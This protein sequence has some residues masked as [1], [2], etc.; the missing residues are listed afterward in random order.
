MRGLAYNPRST[1]RGEP[2]EQLE[3]QSYAL[4]RVRS[5]SS[6]AIPKWLRAGWTDLTRAPQASLFYGVVLT[7][8]GYLLTRFIGQGAYALALITGFLLMGPFLSM[9]LYDISRTLER[10]ES[11]RLTATLLAWRANLPAIGLYA[12]ILALLMAVWMRVSVVVVA[13]FFEGGVPSAAT[14]WSDIVRADQGLVFLLV[15]AAAGFGF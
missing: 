3:Q 15:Y 5:I 4:P 8:M 2:M 10:G 6:Q 1:D 14:L 12:I 11:V 9:G 7:A 13:L